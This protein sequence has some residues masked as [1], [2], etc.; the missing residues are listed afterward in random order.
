VNL[1]TTTKITLSPLVFG[2]GSYVALMER[3]GSAGLVGSTYQ[4]DLTVTAIHLVITGLLNIQS[5]NLVVSQATSHADFPKTLQCGTVPQQSVSGHAFVAQ[6][7]N[8]PTIA[9]TTLGY[10]AIPPTGGNEE[11]ALA[12]V[13]LPLLTSASVADSRSF[14][15]MTATRSFS[16][17]STEVGG[18]I[19]PAICIGRL[20]PTKCLVTAQVLHTQSN[21]TA[22]AAGA[23]STDAGTKLLN[24]SVLGIP[25][26]LSVPP[27]TAVI[28]PGFGY[29]VLNE[30]FCD[31]GGLT[32]THKCTGT[33]HSGLTVRAVDLVFTFLGSGL[34]VV[35]ATELIVGEAHSDAT[36]GG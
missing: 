2:K 25:L 8:D 17:S 13:N 31:G 6:L 27:N 29:V 16:S 11:Q 9:D 35:P 12:S 4:A 32:F 36:F 33:H 15:D 23:T 14:S 3:T 1:N 22:T 21:S 5:L 34:G 28:I 7:R 24:V 10:V 30:Q 18:N 26:G 20:S 19:G